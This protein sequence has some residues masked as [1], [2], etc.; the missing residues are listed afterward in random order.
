M[1]TDSSR[2]NP[3]TQDTPLSRRKFLKA[4]L[5]GGVAVS[6][7]PLWNVDP[8]PHADPSSESQK[9]LRRIIRKYGGEF[10]GRDSV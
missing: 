5:T 3:E 8:A 7:L 4:G 10:G 9:E 1:N 6:T 2:K